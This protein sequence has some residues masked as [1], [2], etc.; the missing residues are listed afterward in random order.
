MVRGTASRFPAEGIKITVTENKEHFFF[1]HYGLTNQDLERY[2]AAALSAGG[3][4][5]KFST[6]SMKNS[7]K[8]LI[9]EAP[10]RLC[11]RKCSSTV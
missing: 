5:T 10:R 8:T 1:E 11:L 3:L 6:R 9:P 2:L 4:P 7:D